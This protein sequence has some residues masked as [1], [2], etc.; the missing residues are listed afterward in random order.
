MSSVCSASAS[1]FAFFAAS[2]AAI[3]SSSFLDLRP[4]CFGITM[5]S[6]SLGVGTSSADS[7]F[8]FVVLDDFSF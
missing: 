3:S 7:L 8:F 4:R 6:A 1:S 2:A 5:A